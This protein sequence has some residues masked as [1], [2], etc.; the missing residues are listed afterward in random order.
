MVAFRRHH[1]RVSLGVRVAL[2]LAITLLVGPQVARP[3]RA[4][5]QRYTVAALPNVNDTCAPDRGGFKA[6][7]SSFGTSLNN[8]ADVAGASM[9]CVD[10][11]SQEAVVWRNGSLFLLFQLIWVSIY[12][13]GFDTAAF[14]INDSGDVVG[15]GSIS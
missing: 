9:Y 5:T 7:S 15:A 2:A 8:S 10:D 1:G 11:F 6:P 13:V 14:G 12:P 3:A 4:L